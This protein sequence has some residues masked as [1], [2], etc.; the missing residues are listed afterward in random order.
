[1]IPHD[2]IKVIDMSQTLEDKAFNSKKHEL[3]KYED[4]ELKSPGLA[5]ILI[6][7]N[8]KYLGTY[9]IVFTVAS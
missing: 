4:V 2:P 8:L 6:G 9:F 7:G 5:W 3:I 1:M